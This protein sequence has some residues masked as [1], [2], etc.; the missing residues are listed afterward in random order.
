MLKISETITLSA[1]KKKSKVKNII[2]TASKIIISAALIYWILSGTDFTE[3]FRAISSA[4]LFLIIIS[5]SLHFIGYYVSAVRWKLLLNT[6]GVDVG[7]PYLIKSYIISTFFNNLLPSTVGGDTVR[8]YDSYKAGKSKSGA[9]AVIF[10]DRFLGLF[11]LMIFALF[12]VFF[13]DKITNQVPYLFLWVIAGFILMMFVVWII[14]FPSKKLIEFVGKLRIPFSSKLQRMSE[15][16][17]GS[18]W[19]FKG[20]KNVLFKA[21]LLSFLLHAN[22]VAY[23]FLIASALNF[24]IPFYNF[25][26]IVPLAIFIMMLPISINGIG[27]RESI[28]FLFFSTFAISKPEAIAF[29]W[30]EYGILLLLGVLGGIVYAFR[31]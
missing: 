29:A 5:F 11:V 16:I 31:K 4:S 7:I 26:L 19:N 25:F 28:F 21:L 6:Q 2:F 10:V 18:F 12:A 23:Y 24:H 8:A 9:V 3:I 30:I 15:K 14:F 20:Q 1:E 13:V 22:V 27:L 17:I